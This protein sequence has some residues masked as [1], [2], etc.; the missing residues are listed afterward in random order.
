MCGDCAGSTTILPKCLR[1]LTLEEEAAPPPDRIIAWWRSVNHPMRRWL[2]KGKGEQELEW[3]EGPLTPGH[4]PN[5]DGEGG[6][7]LALRACAE[8]GHRRTVAHCWR[9]VRRCLG[10]RASGLSEQGGCVQA[11]LERCSCVS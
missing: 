2:H 11:W 7:S 6:P 9:S 10:G 1:P 8:A 3:G 5:F 4:I